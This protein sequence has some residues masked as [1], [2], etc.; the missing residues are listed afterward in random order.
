MDW[1][2]FKNCIQWPVGKGNRIKFWVFDWIEG[3]CLMRSFP[4]IYAI[5]Q[6]KNMKI[7]DAYKIIDGSVVWLVNVIRNLNDWKVNEYESL[8]QTLETQQI[9]TC[10]DK[11][12]GN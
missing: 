9:N 12:C 8:L 1:P 10:S 6:S 2:R 3:S 5:A 4:S 7:E 11:I